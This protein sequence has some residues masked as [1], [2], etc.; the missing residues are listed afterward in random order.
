MA[1]SKDIAIHDT[2]GVEACMEYV[3]DDEKTILSNMGYDIENMSDEELLQAK[4]SL[5]DVNNVFEYAR[6]LDKTTFVLDGDE[7]ILVSGYRCN[8]KTASIEFQCSR[9]NYYRHVGLP[10]GKVYGTK[11]I[12]K[13]NRETGE[14]TRE[15]VNKQSI[16]AFHII[17]SFPEIPGLDPRLVHHLGLEFAKRAFP[18]HKAV[19]STHMNTKHLHNHLVVCAY[20]EDSIGKY[21][22]NMEHRNQY[23][24]INDEISLEYGLPV[25]LDVDKE[26][27]SLTWL[28]WNA[29]RNGESWKAQIREDIDL[30]KSRAKNWEDFLRIMESGGYKIRIGKKYVTY[31]TPG[32]DVYKARDKSLGKGYTKKDIIAELGQ[33][34]TSKEVNIT[35]GN[36]ID[37]SD[38]N[39][40]GTEK[41]RNDPL[42]KKTVSKPFSLKVSRYT[43]T[44][45]RRSD[46]EIIFLKAIKIIK[47]FLDKFFDK[48]S[49]DAQPT[50]PVY[51]R[52]D[53]KL[54]AMEQALWACRQM[55]IETVAE[56]KDKMNTV[57]MELSQARHELNDLTENIEFGQDVV[58]KIKTINE[59]RAKIE[60]N[61]ELANIDLKL[62]VY[63]DE[64]IAKTRASRMPMSPKQRQELFLKTDKEG[65]K[66]DRP[67]NQITYDEAR[68]ILRYLNGEI[69]Y[70]SPIIITEEEFEAKRRNRKYDAIREKQNE[71]LIEASKDKAPSPLMIDKLLRVMQDKGL[72]IDN[73]T[74]NI[75]KL[76]VNV[77]DLTFAEI[78][79]ILAKFAD[80][81]FNEEFISDK[82]KELIETLLKKTGNALNRDI[83]YITKSEGAALI[84]FLKEDKGV[85]PNVIK[86]SAPIKQSQINQ[87][88]DLLIAKGETCNIPIEQ[89]S[90]IDANNLIRYL[91]HKD[92]LLP[93]E[94][95]TSEDS[96]KLNRL[97]FDE[98]IKALM[99]EEKQLL[100]SYR[101][102]LNDL[103]MCGV[104]ISELDV[105]ESIQKYNQL[106]YNSV[107]AQVETLAEE[108]KNLRKLNFSLNLAQTKAF[109]HGPLYDR[110]ELIQEETLEQATADIKREDEMIEKR[111]EE[112]NKSVDKKSNFFQDIEEAFFS[113]M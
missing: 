23:R 24:A 108:Y 86:P 36:D 99:P 33:E 95:E 91:L 83:S 9:N 77:H 71:N 18:N 29:N 80:N 3:T 22:M 68:D 66:L 19:V 13:I 11:V 39:M 43:E 10:E 110:D 44:G 46:L 2:K 52:A 17:Q 69:T 81:P 53:K 30:A 54:K 87:I 47:Y 73:N 102:L 61:P 79:M 97:I 6:N 25:L 82:Q 1:I 27:E 89:L 92:E 78:S 4:S 14:I 16:E 106:T 34:R 58:E 41:T 21:H 101:E 96:K 113:R 32:S 112:Q 28:E 103:K 12:E 84:R 20:N 45:R 26:H 5:Y 85:I 100:I 31:T 98:D 38:I 67:F 8:P 63:S 107:N 65:V 74:I 94:N 49:Y 37:Y 70:K 57:G 40:G 75:G 15:T 76:T 88:N 104:D 62:N 105:Y 50:N 51:Q 56:L 111:V 93:M 35:Q 90:S 72:K 60:A 42:A 48:T 55:G 59:M 64:E 7:E 109:T